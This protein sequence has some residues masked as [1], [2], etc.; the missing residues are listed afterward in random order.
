MTKWLA[1][2][3]GAVALVV[4]VAVGVVVWAQPGGGGSCDRTLLSTALS[5][6]IQAANQQAKAQ[7][8]VA[9]PAACTEDDIASVLP[10]VTRVWHMMP[11]GILMRE[12]SHTAATP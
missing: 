9:R 6:G 4:A 8:E 5:D 11:G 7:F 10:E 2:A 3:I 12:P 1:P